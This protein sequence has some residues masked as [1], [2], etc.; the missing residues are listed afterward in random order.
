MYSAGF[1]V[2]PARLVFAFVAEMEQHRVHCD[3][4]QDEG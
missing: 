1:T 3:P 2:D 4:L